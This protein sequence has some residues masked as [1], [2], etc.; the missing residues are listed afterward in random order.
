MNF[1]PSKHFCIT[2]FKFSPCVSYYKLSKS[3]EK[4]EENIERSIK[5]KELG[6]SSEDNIRKA[7]DKTVK[8]KICA[9]EACTE[10]K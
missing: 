3:A 4:S 1:K 6:Q 2:F 7:T 10:Y 9:Q 5:M 8:L